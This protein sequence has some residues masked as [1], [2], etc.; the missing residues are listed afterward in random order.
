[1]EGAWSG[2]GLDL[3]EAGVWKGPG[4]GRGLDLEEA[5]VCTRVY[6][7]RRRSKLKLELA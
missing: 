3:E 5:G 4:F 1:M 7:Q 2:R 6:L